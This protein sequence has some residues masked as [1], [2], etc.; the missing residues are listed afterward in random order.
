V[1]VAVFKGVC[2]DVRD[3]RPLVRQVGRTGDRVAMF[4]GWRDR[5]S[6]RTNLAMSG[7]SE[8]RPGRATVIGMSGTADSAATAAG[9]VL[10]RRERHATRKRRRRDAASAGREQIGR[11][12]TTL[13]RFQFKSWRATWRTAW[14][15]TLAHGTTPSKLA[16]T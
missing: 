7:M 2:D 12:F 13:Q 5:M 8:P 14:T 15:A 11:G 1:V 4:H 6:R 16:A 3:H 9:R 10:Q